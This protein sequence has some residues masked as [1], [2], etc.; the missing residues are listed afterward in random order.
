MTGRDSLRY[1]RVFDDEVL[2]TVWVANQVL[3]LPFDRLW[4]EPVNLREQ[5]DALEFF[6]NLL[7]NLDEGLKALSSKPLFSDILGGSFADQKICKGCPHRY[8]YPFYCYVT[9]VFRKSHS[10]LWKREGNWSRNASRNCFWD[11]N[12]ERVVPSNSPR[13]L[14][15]RKLDPGLFSFLSGELRLLPLLLET[16]WIQES[17][18]P[19]P[20]LPGHQN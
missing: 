5:H 8:E 4:G 11:R 6:N 13:S 1:V 3:L 12:W 15:E 10:Q 2:R 14:C 16:H 18:D 7:D 9:G 17:K 20:L 19:T